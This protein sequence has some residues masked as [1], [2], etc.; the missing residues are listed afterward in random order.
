MTYV[1]YYSITA[2]TVQSQQQ[3]YP[4][5]CASLEAFPLRQWSN[6]KEKGMAAWGRQSFKVLYV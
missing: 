6:E 1:I 2:Q 3:S 5:K 4:H